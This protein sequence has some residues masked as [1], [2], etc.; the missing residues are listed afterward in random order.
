LFANISYERVPEV[1]AMSSA[2][3]PRI[4]SVSPPCVLQYGADQRLDVFGGGFTHDSLIFVD[5]HGLKTVFVDDRHLGTILDST[6]VATTG[7]KTVL[8]HDLDTGSISNES[9]VQVVMRIEDCTAQSRRESGARTQRQALGVTFPDTVAPSAHLVVTVNG[10]GDA[11]IS[12][13]IAAASFQQDLTVTQ[14]VDLGAVNQAGLYSVVISTSTGT[15]SGLITI[16]PAGASFSVL[17]DDVDG[18]LADPLPIFDPEPGGDAIDHFNQ[19][20][21]LEILQAAVGKAL[22]DHP[23]EI[24]LAAGTTGIICL[25][26]GAAGQFEIVAEELVDATAAAMSFIIEATIDIMVND[27]HVLSPEDGAN[28]KH[29]LNFTVLISGLTKIQ[30][31]AKAIENI[32]AA[33]GATDSAVDL[34]DPNDNTKLV[35]K[36]SSGFF[37]RAIMMVRIGH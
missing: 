29:L 11:V 8:V 12:T 17:H 34:L 23:A 19:A 1:I 18:T 37:H 14:D 27:R 30:K 25:V 24:G 10:V 2:S 28:L 36:A 31:D 5:G 3:D 7:T 33:V 35:S 32:D 6:T 20:V 22:H 13:D 9:S 15:Y 16:L 4:D 21:T 26:A